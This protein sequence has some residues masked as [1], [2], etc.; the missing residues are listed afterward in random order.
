MAV[1]PTTRRSFTRAAFILTSPFSHHPPA[2]VK[3]TIGWGSPGRWARGVPSHFLR[4][5]RPLEKVPLPN[6]PSSPNLTTVLGVA[7]VAQSGRASP[8]QGECRGF[9]SLHSLQFPPPPVFFP[10]FVVI[11][12][13]SSASF[14]FS[15]RFLFAFCRR[16]T[17]NGRPFGIHDTRK[18]LP[19][20]VTLRWFPKP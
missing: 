1:P 13:S 4:S 20:L 3:G 6:R 12:W 19:W 11:G 2:A 16:L 10:R 8:C 14:S 15:F 5:A 17:L 9:E 18:R 7:S